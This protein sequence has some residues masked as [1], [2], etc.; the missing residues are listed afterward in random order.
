MKR[1]DAFGEFAVARTPALYRSAYLLC[2]DAQLAEDLV[3]ETLAK[4]Y[5]VWGRRGIDN[6]AAYAHTT[7]VRTYISMARRRSS[8]EVPA[9]NLPDRP[10]AG[11]EIS[12]RLDLRSALSG[13]NQTDRA[14]LVLRFLEDLSV[15]QTADL[16]SISPGAVRVRTHRALA[17]M[18]DVLETKSD[19]LGGQV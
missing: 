9:A 18:R 19:C 4:I 6:V 7:L 16:L 11:H 15:Q 12:D 3:Q 17:R 1:D 8:G 13:L 5:K 10:A 14:V 2:S